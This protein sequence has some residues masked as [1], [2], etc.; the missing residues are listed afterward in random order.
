M[1]HDRR[2]CI[3]DS[4]AEKASNRFRDSISE[5]YELGWMDGS[6]DVY[7]RAEAIIKTKDEEGKWI[8]KNG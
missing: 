1:N 4:I 2:K 6:Q 5:A 3:V 8:E 7:D